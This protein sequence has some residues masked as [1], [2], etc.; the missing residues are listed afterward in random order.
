MAATPLDEATGDLPP[1]DSESDLIASSLMDKTLTV[2]REWVRAGA[3]TTWSDCAGLSPEL[4]S[5]YLQFGN[6]SIDL[7][8][9]LW[10][11]RAP[12]TTRFNWWCHRVKAGGLSTDIMIPYSLDIWVFPGQFVGF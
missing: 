11:R 7:D 9:Q 2:V 1:S 5:W 10:R 4:R 3:P 8:G 6:L 12:P